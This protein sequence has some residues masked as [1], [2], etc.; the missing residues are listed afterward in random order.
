MTTLVNSKSDILNK[1]SLKIFLDTLSVSPEQ[2]KHAEDIVNELIRLG[3]KVTVTIFT[4]DSPEEEL[5]MVMNGL[6]MKGVLFYEY[7]HFRLGVL[8]AYQL[9]IKVI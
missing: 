5:K 2:T 7:W 9:I 6:N 4:K 3:K 8:E 1:K